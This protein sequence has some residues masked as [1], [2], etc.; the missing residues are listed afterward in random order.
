[1][2]TV[3]TMACKSTTFPAT[4]RYVTAWLP[5][6][7]SHLAH[8]RSGRSGGLTVTNNRPYLA[9]TKD[10]R[11]TSPS[12]YP[13]PAGTRIERLASGA[14]ADPR[15]AGDYLTRDLAQATGRRSEFGE[16][17]TRHGPDN[18]AGRGG[19]RRA[20]ANR[21]AIRVDGTPW[22]SPPSRGALP[23][24]RGGA[25][26]VLAGKRTARDTRGR[27]RPRSRRARAESST[28]QPHGS[29]SAAEASR[30]GRADLSIRPLHRGA[31]Q[32]AITAFL[33][34]PIPPR[35]EPTSHG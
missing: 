6:I 14:A 2:R 1:M 35:S 10:G 4:Q 13:P 30:G 23:Y 24:P 28:T 27:R 9:A 20:R 29:V 15:A 8:R 16:V 17:F 21:A 32:A 12:A 11:C 5:Q 22:A 19:P 31:L 3:T 18:G 34:G 26:R 7:C 33:I 25:G